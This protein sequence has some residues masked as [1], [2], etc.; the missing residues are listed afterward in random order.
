MMIIYAKPPHRRFKC[1]RAHVTDALATN[2]ARQLEGSE[3]CWM[4]PGTF[5]CDG[6][7]TL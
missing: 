7:S 2:L 1:L 5:D 4:V 3:S 6:N